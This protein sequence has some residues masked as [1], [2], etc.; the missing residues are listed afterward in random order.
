MSLMGHSRRFYDVRVMSGLPPIATE[1]RTSLEVWFVPIT[2]ISL[3]HPIKNALALPSNPSYNTKSWIA[4]HGA[5][6]ASPGRA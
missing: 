1:L 2:D 4:R 3:R 5:G 6:A